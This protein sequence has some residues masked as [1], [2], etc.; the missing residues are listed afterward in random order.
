MATRYSRRLYSGRRARAYGRAYRFPKRSAYSRRTGSTSYRGYGSYAAIAKFAAPYALRAIP[1]VYRGY[2]AYQKGGTGGLK[3]YAGK[4][5]S[6]GARAAIKAVTGYGA[7][8]SVGSGGMTGKQAPA[9]RNGALDGGSIVISNKEFLGDVYSGGTLVNGSTKLNT[10]TFRLNPGETSTFPWLSQLSKNYQQYRIEGMCF[11]YKSMSGNALNSTNTGLGSVI[12]CTQ[13]DVTNPVPDSKAEME[14]MEFAQSIKPSESITHFIECAKSQST[15]SELYVN[16]NPDDIT[17]DP[18]FYDFGKFTIGTQG[19]QATNVN[20]GE[21]WVS[22]Q[23]RLFKPQLYDALGRDVQVWNFGSGDSAGEGSWSNGN[24][25]TL[26]NLARPE[27]HPA[28]FYKNNSLKCVSKV[29]LGLLFEG[30]LIPKTYLVRLY[31]QSQSAGAIDIVTNFVVTNCTLITEFLG[32][33]VTG[34]SSQ[35]SPN[36]GTNSFSVDLTFTVKVDPDSRGQPWGFGFSSAPTISYGL[37]SRM[38]ITIV[39]IPYTPN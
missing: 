7:Y 31:Y 2:K 32:N 16:E 1:Y 27:L 38:E 20:L 39:E 22:Y 25:F 29:P 19:M 11:H 34:A 17:G 6:R 13:Y 28:Y 12:L 33:N 23:I 10:S 3:R 14:N 30:T 18:R 37:N 9:I 8:S 35:V 24:P 26:L 4:L 15:L 21:L 5:A 36:T